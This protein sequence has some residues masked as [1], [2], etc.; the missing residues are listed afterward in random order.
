MRW[1]MLTYEVPLGRHP[2]T[3]NDR[4]LA[5]EA[6]ASQTADAGLPRHRR[7]MHRR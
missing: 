1:G 2:H 3:F 6:L 7:E 4:P 5:Y